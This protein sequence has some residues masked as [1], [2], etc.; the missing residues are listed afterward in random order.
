MHWPTQCLMHMNLRS[1]VIRVGTD[2]EW[3]WWKVKHFKPF[4]CMLTDRPT[5]QTHTPDQLEKT[6]WHSGKKR[7]QPGA[8]IIL[9]RISLQVYSDGLLK[10]NIFMEEWKGLYLACSMLVPVTCETVFAS[11][12]TAQTSRSSQI[13]I[14]FQFGLSFCLVDGSSCSVSGAGCWNST[15]NWMCDVRFYHSVTNSHI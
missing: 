14:Y 5:I 9:I 2:G 7:I 3:S 10:I 13:I 4:I 12:A 6:T 11:T 8:H 1:G 15:R